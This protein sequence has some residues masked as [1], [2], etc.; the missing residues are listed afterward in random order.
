MLYNLEAFLQLN[1]LL[2]SCKLDGDVKKKTKKKLY[3][4][5]KGILKVFNELR[6]SE[7]PEFIFYWRIEPDNIPFSDLERACNLIK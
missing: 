4:I 3:K 7:E 5:T 6:K 2:I 1:Y